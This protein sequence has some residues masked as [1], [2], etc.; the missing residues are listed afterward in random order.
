M[1][2][3][4]IGQTAQTKR[5]FNLA[6]LD[7]YAA[8]TGTSTPIESVIPGPLLGGL[9][10]YLLGTKLPGRG[11]NYLKQHLEFPIPAHVGEKLTATVEIVRLRPEKGLVNLRTTCTNPRGEIVCLGDALVKAKD[12]E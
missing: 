5:T 3:F 1:K 12:M 8:L 10:S 11:T 7:E 2:E 9:F 6:D 4:Q